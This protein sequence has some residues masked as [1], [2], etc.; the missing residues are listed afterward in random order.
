MYL[1]M[2]KFNQQLTYKKGINL[3]VGMDVFL[4]L[5]RT[6]F[7]YVDEATL[8]QANKC[9]KLKLMY[10]IKVSLWSH[11]KKNIFVGFY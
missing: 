1:K 2:L 5:F 11:L 8:F 6:G 7:N 9:W 10:V 4:T 3:G